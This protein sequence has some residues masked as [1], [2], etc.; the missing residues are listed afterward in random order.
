MK[1][2]IN[3]LNTDQIQIQLFESFQIKLIVVL[4]SICF[5]VDIDFI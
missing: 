3:K 1:I 4:D 2:I 5:V